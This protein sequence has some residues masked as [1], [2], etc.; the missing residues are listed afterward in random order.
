MTEKKIK[1][2][3]VIPAR[4]DS[5]RVKNKNIRPLNG[6]PLL[7][8]TVRAS[9]QSKLLDKIVLST[10]SADIA[11]IGRRNKIEVPFIRPG[12]IST[13]ESTDR[14]YLAHCVEWYVTNRDY[15]PDF[16]V[17][18]RPTT[19]F[20]T[21]ELIDEA[22]AII[23]ERDVGSVRTVTRVTGVHHPYWMYLKDGDNLGRPFLPGISKKK[24]FQSQTLPPVFRLNGVVDV[25]KAGN[26]YTKDSIYGEDIFLHEI[27]ED[28]SFD[29]DTELDFKICELLMKDIHR[30]ERGSI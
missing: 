22:I 21:A 16:L 24:Y 14:E 9:L 15:H 29:I 6:E 26:I 19:P 27:S 4:K 17:I 7:L 28:I 2:L 12:N 23:S 10:D 30:R 25:I 18:L 8:Y 3:G 5:K 1:V 20:K 13:D 11:E